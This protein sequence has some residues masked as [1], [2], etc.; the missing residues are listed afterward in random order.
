MGGWEGICPASISEV[1]LWAVAGRI[2][3]SVF[4]V[5]FRAVQI[6]EE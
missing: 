2:S 6:A 1:K 3:A 5:V 4:P